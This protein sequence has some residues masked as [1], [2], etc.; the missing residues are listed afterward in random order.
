VAADPW[1]GNILDGT[2]EGSKCIQFSS[3][4][5]NKTEGEEDCLLLNVYTHD[6]M[7][8]IAFNANRLQFKINN[9]IK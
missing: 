2:K 9:E 4:I 6:V 3:M 1:R 7:I 8:H 5:Y